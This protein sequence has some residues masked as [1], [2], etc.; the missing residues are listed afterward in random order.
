[1][2]DQIY[3]M[4]VHCKIS[5]ADPDHALFEIV[6]KLKQFIIRVYKKHGSPQ[7]EVW[8]TSEKLDRYR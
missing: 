2:P 7:E 5:L 4:V 1:M 8:I 3:L 6:T